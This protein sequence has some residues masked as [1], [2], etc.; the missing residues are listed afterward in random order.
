MNCLEFRRT[1]LADPA[2]AGDEAR[3]HA[4][5][6]SACGEFLARTRGLD[7]AIAEAMALPAPDGLE[8]R[9]FEH[10]RA[11]AQGGRRRFL[12]M[13]ASLAG[14][15]IVGAG[16]YLATR[17]DADAL[18]GIAFVVE[19]EAHAI[20]A[21]GPADEAELLR[22]ARSMG[23]RLPSQLGEIRYIG[24]CP[25]RG[26]IAHHVIVTTPQGKAT[27]LL[28]PEKPVAQRGRAA[29]R[30]L[31]SIVLPAGRGSATVIAESAHGLERIES[32]MRAA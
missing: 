14:L 12:A 31:R 20:L 16:S 26:T 2:A 32:M 13:A 7:D 4:A 3:A 15:A 27:L 25:Y 1:A 11:R 23:L 28:L 29:A 30:G 22:V 18:A 17:D 24:T 19:E 5:A 9:I 8:A 21:A 6:C 10:A